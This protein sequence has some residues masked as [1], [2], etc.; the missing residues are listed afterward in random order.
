MAELTQQ[1]QSKITNQTKKGIL[2]N[3]KQ[4]ILRIPKK[5][6]EDIQSLT[7]IGTPIAWLC[8]KTQ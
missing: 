8:A 3:L 5:L 4:L 6:G 7:V 2:S 1:Y